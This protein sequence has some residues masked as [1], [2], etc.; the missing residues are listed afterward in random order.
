[1]DRRTADLC[2]AA[3]ARTL[4]G[5]VFGPAIAPRMKKPDDLPGVTI[6]S[7]QV[8]TLVKIAAVACESE[9][10]HVI[11]ST[12]LLRDDVLDMMRQ[13][14]VFLAQPA[15]FSTLVSAMPDQVPCARFHL[16]LKRGVELLPGFELENRDEVRC[17]DE[18][19]IF[20]KLAFAQG[21]LVRPFCEFLHT[22]LHGRANLQTDNATRGLRI[23]ASAQ[24]LQQTVQ[25][26][27]CAH[28][29]T[30]AWAVRTKKR[31]SS[32]ATRAAASGPPS[33]TDAKPTRRE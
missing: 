9:I 21:A 17:V 7:G 12:V 2:Q 18:R 27:Y 23:E 13:F 30:L 33:V 15:I 16:L 6:D 4:K 20:R 24:G 31:G 22:L 25:A 10:I 19:L 11:G 28:F 14:A 32:H 29:T 5:E 3:Y 26:H 8:W 1:M